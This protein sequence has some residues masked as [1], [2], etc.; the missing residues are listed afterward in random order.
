M[1]HFII[2]TVASSPGGALTPKQFKYEANDFPTQL[3]VSEFA[4]KKSTNNLNWVVTGLIEVTK[5][6]GKRYLSG[7]PFSE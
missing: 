7:I 2:F 4:T 5:E 1:R 3:E 6:I